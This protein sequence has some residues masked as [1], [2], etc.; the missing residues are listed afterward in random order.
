MEPFSCHNKAEPPS[1]FMFQ[2]VCSS[3]QC[4]TI[5]NCFK[6]HSNLS[7]IIEQRCLFINGDNENRMGLSTKEM[8]N[9]GRLSQISGGDQSKQQLRKTGYFLSFVL[10]CSFYSCHVD[11]KSDMCIFAFG[12]SC[13]ASH[14]P[15]DQF[16]FIIHHLFIFLQVMFRSRRKEECP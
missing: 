15:H 13:I 10:L 1:K 11:G 12:C 2:C 7:T 5:W 9:K 6:C 4:C 14:V 3:S 16:F 8:V